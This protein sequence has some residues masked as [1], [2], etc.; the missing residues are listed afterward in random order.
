MDCIFQHPFYFHHRQ[1]PAVSV[2]AVETPHPTTWLQTYSNHIL[3][4]HCKWPHRA[5]PSPTKRSLKAQADRIHWAESLPL[6]LLGVGT[7]YK[8]DIGCTAAE[9][10]YGTTLRLPGVPS[11]TRGNHLLSLSIASSLRTSIRSLCMPHVSTLQSLYLPLHS[12]HESHVLV[13][14]SVGHKGLFTTFSSLGGGGGGGSSVVT[15]NSELS[16]EHSMPRGM[17]L[18][19]IYCV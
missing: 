9:L 8:A 15:L 4:S 5:F 2:L 10:V 16:L 12:H 13:A 17:H 14:M 19:D 3:S 7:P 11:T 1:G 6:V 18:Y